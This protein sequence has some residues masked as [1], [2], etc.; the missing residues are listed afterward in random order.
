MNSAEGSSMN[1]Y[2]PIEDVTIPTCEKECDNALTHHA[3]LGRRYALTP[4]SYK[5]LE[6]GISVGI[7]SY[8]ELALEA[9]E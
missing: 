8:V 9:I 4:T 5:Y 1:Y 6:I 2:A 3:V 7:T